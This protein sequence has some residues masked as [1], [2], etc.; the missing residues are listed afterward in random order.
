ML[1]FTFS[2]QGY[3]SLLTSKSFSSEFANGLH[4]KK[5]FGIR[6]QLFDCESQNILVRGE[7]IYVI[8]YFIRIN[9]VIVRQNNS[10]ETPILLRGPLV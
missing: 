6:V 4:L 8:M 10:G 5:I 9:D 1:S 7:K 3:R 2:F